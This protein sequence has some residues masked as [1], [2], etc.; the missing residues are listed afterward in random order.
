MTEVAE[1]QEMSEF[2]DGKTLDVLC[3][4]NFRRARDA[5]RS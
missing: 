1:I 5:G 4:S 2:S 3:T